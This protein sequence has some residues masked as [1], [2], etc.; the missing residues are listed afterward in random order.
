M[1]KI[2]EILK[3]KNAQPL[4]N[5]KTASEIE[6]NC[7]ICKDAGVVLPLKEDGR[8]DYS[9]TIP[10]ECQ[11][12]ALRDRRMMALF[13]YC[14]LPANSERFSFENFKT[15]GYGDLVIAINYAKNLADEN[16]DTKWLVFVSPVD[17][18]KSHL[19][20]AI[21]RRWLERGKAAKYVLVPTMLEWLR[22]GYENEGEFNKRLNILMDIP[23][24]VLDDLG[25]QSVS[26]WAMEKIMMIVDHRYLNE[27][28][29]VVTTN[30]PLDKLPGDDEGRIE[31]RLRRFE[32]GKIIVL[33]SPEYRTWR[34]K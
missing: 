14:D 24:L 29:L 25:T 10:C 18:G 5:S 4:P 31:S 9:R 6:Y 23:L 34:R 12:D 19:A 7:A 20:L 3:N 13:Q 15:G 28:P 32:K 30:K 27:L 26:K 2:G 11:A 21:C 22:Q 8:V 16:D 33:D 17:R 1:E